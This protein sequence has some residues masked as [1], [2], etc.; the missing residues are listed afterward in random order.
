[1]GILKSLFTLGKSIIAQADESIEDAQGVRI[2][3][4]HI[5]DANNELGKAGKSRVDLLARVKLSQDKLL[6]LRTRK[7]SL[8]ARALEAMQKNVDTTLLNE[9][10]QEIAHLE[11]AIATEEQVMVTLDTSRDAVEKAVAATSHRISQFEQQLEVIKATDAMQRAQQ[12]ITASTAGATSSVAT[13]AD[14]L[15][16]LQERQAERQARLDAATQ[17]EKAANGSDLDEKLAQAGIGSAG[18]SSAEDVLARLKQCQQG[19]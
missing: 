5:R 4:Q 16:R 2:L 1:M 14:S 9:V 13:A 3:E 6:D 15:K 11:N 7:S 17:L 18:K 8:E 19:Q 10:A 12:A